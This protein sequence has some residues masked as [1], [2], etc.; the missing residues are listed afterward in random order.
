MAEKL[1]DLGNGLWIAQ[2]EEG[3]RFGTDAVLLADFAKDYI[4]PKKTTV[5]IGT[6]SGIIPLLLSKKAPLEKITCFEIQ[7]SAARR[8][9]KN[10]ALNRLQDK[11]KIVDRDVRS[12]DLFKSSS[13]D[14]II[15]N[16]PYTPVD[17]GLAASPK[18]ELALS[19]SEISLNLSEL[20]DFAKIH[21][22]D[23]GKLIMIHRPERFGEI[24]CEAEKKGLRLKRARFVHPS[25]KKRPTM[26]LL[27]VVKKARPGL[28]IEPPLILTEDGHYSAEVDA[29]YEGSGPRTTLA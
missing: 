16:P 26:V 29:I 4:R 25:A 13:I 23:K 7:K 11:I 1:E 10:V 12:Q 6:G 24:V 9:K 3:F 15:T 19:R 2:D 22:K 27:E 20:F 17:T 5:E 8:A 21:L 18:P 28:I 14:L